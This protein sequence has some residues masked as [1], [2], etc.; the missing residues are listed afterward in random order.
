LIIYEVA[1]YPKPFKLNTIPYL[2]KPTVVGGIKKVI[3]GGCCVITGQTG[4][5]YLEAL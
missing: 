4:N 3:G 1:F 5:I 2:K